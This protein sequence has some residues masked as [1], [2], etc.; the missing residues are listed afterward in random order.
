MTLSGTGTRLMNRKCHVA[1]D[2]E[3]RSIY[4][5]EPL[6]CRSGA[7]VEAERRGRVP[8]DSPR[9]VELDCVTIRQMRRTVMRRAISGAAFVI[10]ALVCCRMSMAQ[11]PVGN[12]SWDACL[13]APTRSCILDE[14]LMLALAVK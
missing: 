7:C 10:L 12:T 3:S 14:A 4:F 8:V 9:A 2:L 6:R 5:I 13:K 1:K 11:G